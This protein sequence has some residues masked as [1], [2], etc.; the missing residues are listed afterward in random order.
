MTSSH[1]Y[2]RDL[3]LQYPDGRHK[4]HPATVPLPDIL[5]VQGE[6]FRRDFSS[7]RNYNLCDENGRLTQDGE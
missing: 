1:L 5:C 6:Y 3:I 2:S 4:I 7:Q